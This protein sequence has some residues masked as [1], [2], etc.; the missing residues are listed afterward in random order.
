MMNESEKLWTDVDNYYTE[1]FIGADAVLGNTLASSAQAGLPDIAVA[2]NQ[3]K[4]LHLLVRMKQARRVLEIG[5]L[6]GYSTIWMAHALPAG[7]Q[8]ITLEL[9][10]KHA[11]VARANFES[12]GVAERVELREG[13]ALQSLKAMVHEKSAPF[14]FIF[15]DADK[16]NIPA[17]FQFALQ[18]SRPG[19]VIIVDN[20][21]RNGAIIDKDNN[22]AS[23]RGV[24]EFNEIAAAEPR[25]MATT[26][27]TVGVKGYDGFTIMLVVDLPANT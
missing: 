6:G 15:I 20:V 21:V 18:L 10:A 19:S 1:L 17:Y 12:A 26:L 4:L 13:A 5:T 16:A 14:D 22:D 24:R 2:P 9:N 8:L 23:V 3:G 7:G 11:A 25:V 27:Q